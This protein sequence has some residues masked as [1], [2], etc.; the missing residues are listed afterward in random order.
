MKPQE[1]M[2]WFWAT[3]VLPGT[4]FDDFGDT[5][6]RRA[7]RWSRLWRRIGRRHAGRLDR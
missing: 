6:E 3:G 4:I 1:K 5:R 2:N 7:E